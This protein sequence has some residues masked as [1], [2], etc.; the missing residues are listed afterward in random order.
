MKYRYVYN[1]GLCNVFILHKRFQQHRE[2][3]LKNDAEE[4][5]IRYAESCCECI[6][7]NKENQFRDCLVSV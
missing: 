2:L 1:I 3:N 6:N 5:E 4:Q 7:K